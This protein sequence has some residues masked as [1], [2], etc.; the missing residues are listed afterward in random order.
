MFELPIRFEYGEAVKRVQR[1][2]I[3]NGLNDVSRDPTV[4]QYRHSTGILSNS[5]IIIEVVIGDGVVYA[6]GYI[7][8]LL[9]FVTWKLVI[10]A[11]ESW[12]DKFDRRRRGGAMM[13]RLHAK[14]AKD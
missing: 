6:R 13:A 11:R 12:L 1:W 10:P 8:T 5:N 4:R 2:S 14:L 3:E 7:Q 9:R